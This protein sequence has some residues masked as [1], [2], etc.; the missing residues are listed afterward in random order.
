MNWTLVRLNVRNVPLS[1][2]LCSTDVLHSSQEQTLVKDR[3]RHLLES[4]HQLRSLDT[5]K[6]AMSPCCRA[7]DPA[8]RAAALQ[9]LLAEIG[10]TIQ[11]S[12][13]RGAQRAF[14]AAAALLSVSREYFTGLQR[15]RQDPPQVPC[16]VCYMLVKG[17]VRAT[18]TADQASASGQRAGRNTAQPLNWLQVPAMFQFVPCI[19]RL[20]WLA[21]IKQ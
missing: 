12:G 19:A 2:T 13:P 20:L 7:Q 21:Y 3:P 11:A 8:R 17:T 16:L 1:R 18:C 15:G 5:P 10:A 14:Q 6:Q 4:S 9:E